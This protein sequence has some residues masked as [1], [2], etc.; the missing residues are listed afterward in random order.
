[1]LAS[2]KVGISSRYCVTVTDCTIAADTM[3]C[4]PPACRAVDHGF[5]SQQPHHHT[6]AVHMLQNHD[7]LHAAPYTQPH[8][9]TRTMLGAVRPYTLQNW[10]SALT[11]ASRASTTPSKAAATRSN[12]R[13]AMPFAGRRPGIRIYMTG[14]D[15]TL[16]EIIMHTCTG[17]KYIRLHIC[18]CRQTSTQS[19]ASSHSLRAGV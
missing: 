10:Q 18:T 9:H 15:I 12:C 17:Q 14:R 3:C 1:M 5:Q 2:F 13:A 16:S 19:A 4:P 6:A 8:S 11:N 7:T